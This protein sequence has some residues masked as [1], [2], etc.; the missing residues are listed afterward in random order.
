MGRKFYRCF[1]HITS[2]FKYNSRPLLQDA[3]EVQG[4]DATMLSSGGTA[5]NKKNRLKGIKKRWFFL[6]TTFFYQYLLFVID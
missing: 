4:C 1:G 2:V 6:E 5:G 3:E